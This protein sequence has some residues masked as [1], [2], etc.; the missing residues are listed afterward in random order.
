MSKITSFY[1][2][3]GNVYELE[4]KIP[5]VLNNADVFLFGDSNIY[6]TAGNV[7]SDTGSLYQ[8]LNSE[9]SIKSWTNLASPGKTT[10]NVCGDFRTWATDENVAKYN[11]EST[12]FIFGCATNDNLDSWS[13][14]YN[15]NEN[16]TTATNAVHFIS[17]LISEKFPKV[18]YHFM[19]PTETDWSKWTGSTEADSRNM[20]EKMPYIIQRLEEVQFPYFD[21]YHKSGITSDMLSDG[22][23]WGGGGYNYTTA[24]TYKIYRGWRGYFLNQ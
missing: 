4:S 24:P 15:G 3:S 10:W 6:Y 19:I 8:R 21:G 17:Q 22:A 12:I 16:T 18:S 14:E 20:A 7:L 1:D 23:H 2:G 9:F 11:K 13:S 5:C